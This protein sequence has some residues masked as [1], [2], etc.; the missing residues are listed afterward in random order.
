MSEAR[1]S[2]RVWWIAGSALVVLVALRF[3]PE[4]ENPL[5][6][7]PV[8]A[9]V[10]VLAEGDEVAA[11]GAHELAAGRPFRLF[12]VLEAKDWRGD[13]VWFSEAPALRLGGREVPR[14]AIRPWPG[15]ADVKVRWF[16]VE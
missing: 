5:A 14:D 13:V 12:A 1:E 9:Y 3:L 4:V 8:A 16:T 11:D 2:R 6:P 15:D 10:A 7:E